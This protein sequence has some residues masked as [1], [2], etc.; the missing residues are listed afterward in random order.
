MPTFPSKKTI[1]G[2]PLFLRRVAGCATAS[3]HPSKRPSLGASFLASTPSHVG[4]CPSLRRNTLSEIPPRRQ[5]RAAEP[6]QLCAVGLSWGA[7]CIGTLGRRALWRGGCSAW[8]FCDRRASRIAGSRAAEPRSRPC[9]CRRCGGWNLRRWP[10][11][12]APT[13]L[14]TM[15]CTQRVFS[16]PPRRPSDRDSNILAMREYYMVL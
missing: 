2:R 3:A 15:F 8:W 5:A 14:L 7:C 11:L 9:W 6:Q 13:Y 4:V 10:R 12:S 16:S 1:T